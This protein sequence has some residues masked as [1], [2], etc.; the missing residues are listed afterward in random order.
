MIITHY[1]QVA[2]TI[3]QCLFS[4]HPSI[5]LEFLK[6][7]HDRYSSSSNNKLLAMCYKEKEDLNSEVARLAQRCDLSIQKLDSY[8]YQAKY[9]LKSLYLCCTVDYKQR[10]ISDNKERFNRHAREASSRLQNIAL[11]ISGYELVEDLFKA[12]IVIC[13]LY[14]PKFLERSVFN[15]IPNDVVDHII[16]HWVMELLPTDFDWLKKFDTTFHYE[17]HGAH[18]LS[19]PRLRTLPLKKVS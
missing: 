1:K 19:H 3:G 4:V 18:Q 11:K 17:Q 8:R 2:L 12:R 5:Y 9:N 15:I 14:K 7:S 13:M 16:R 10:A 6:K